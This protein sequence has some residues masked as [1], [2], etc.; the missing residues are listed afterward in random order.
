MY[1]MKHTSLL[2]ILTLPIHRPS[3]LL[4]ACSS[5][6]EKNCARNGILD[7]LP[8][9]NITY[10]VQLSTLDLDFDCIAGSPL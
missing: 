6:M 8:R 9:E 5:S 10:R 7:G 1:T 2:L 4:S 3:L